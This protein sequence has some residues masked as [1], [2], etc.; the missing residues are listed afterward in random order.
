[1]SDEK[2]DAI[3]I[4]TVD[5]SET[6]SIVTFF[7]KDF[8]KVSALAK[9]ARRKKG[10]F[11][12]AL[13]LLATCRI[14]FLHKTGDSLDLLTE[15]KLQHRLRASENGLSRLYSSY[16]IA[17]LL[18]NFTDE[19]DPHPRLYDVT[20]ECLRDFENPDLEYEPT[21]LR[22]EFNLLQEIGQQPSLRKCVACGQDVVKSKRI[23][24]GMLAGG[25]LCS[26]CRI[27]QRRIVSLR[28]EVIDILSEFGDPDSS[29]WRNNSSYQIH[30]KEI[31]PF[32]NNYFAELLGKRPRMFGY[33]PILGKS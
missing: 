32:V 6:S 8:G 11:E 16:Y 20:Q 14:V 9:G 13:D 12:S 10:P 7:T 2:T 5:F 17:E 26:G 19:M 25:V 30:E 3:V 4:R 31:R 29:D 33:I 28:A 21:V 18:L 22:Y 15:A 23:A 27:G 1:M 24:F